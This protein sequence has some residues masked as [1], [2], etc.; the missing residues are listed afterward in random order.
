MGRLFLLLALASCS[1]ARRPQAPGTGRAAPRWIRANLHAHAGDRTPFIGDD[2]YLSPAA[3]HKS[4]Q[5]AGVQLS[6]HTPHSTRNREGDVARAFE[7]QAIHERRFPG[8]V[9]G[10]ELTVA[11]GPN[12]RNW[13]RLAGVQVPGNLNHLGLVGIRRFV[14]DGTPLDQACDAAHGDGGVCI[15]FHPGPGPLMWE[16]GLWERPG[17]RERIDALEVYN[18]L[19]LT[20]AGLHFEQRYRDA[21]AYSGLGIHVA[22][23][24][25]ADV[26]GPDEPARTR[27]RLGVLAMLPLQSIGNGLGERAAIT[28]AAAR[29]SRLAAVLDAVRA[30]RTVATFGLADLALECADLGQVRH[31]GV[32]DLRLRLGRPVGRVRLWREGKAWREWSHVRE[33]HFRD[34]IVQPTSYSFSIEDGA[35]RAQ[36]SGIWYEPPSGG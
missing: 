28:L 31:T 5:A 32:V 9:L 35:G 22:A 29:D 14:P 20:S 27:K 21:I 12:H 24:A 30:R 15:V 18:G 19:A 3:L 1:G 2:G 17:H 36:T 26:H 34:R 7:R 4:L 13:K 8:A 10:E 11:S 16:P 6:V 33:V 23:V 25:G